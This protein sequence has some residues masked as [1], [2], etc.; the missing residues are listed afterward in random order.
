MSESLIL[1]I[2]ELWPILKAEGQ[3]FWKYI[4]L[5]T[6]EVKT[7]EEST[8]LEKA[9]LNVNHPS[10]KSDVHIAEIIIL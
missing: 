4:T 1:N 6:T 7:Y 5:L 9:H 10:C 8:I 2:L 3:L